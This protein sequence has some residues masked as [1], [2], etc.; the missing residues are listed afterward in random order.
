MAASLFT[1]RPRARYPI[2]RA[3]A[4]QK[5]TTPTYGTQGRSSSGSTN[6]SAQAV[7]APPKPLWLIPSPINA[8]RR[9]TTNTLSAAH[10][11][12]TDPAVSSDGR[13]DDHD[14][15]TTTMRDRVAGA[16]G[17][18]SFAPLPPFSRRSESG[19]GSAE[20]EM[21]NDQAPMTNK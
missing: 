14:A 2:A 16:G 18:V 17:D 10:A 6:A 13:N 9:D 12:A 19:A 3:V 8:Q 21:P 4:M 15:R 7:P 5:T 20:R 11:T 1:P